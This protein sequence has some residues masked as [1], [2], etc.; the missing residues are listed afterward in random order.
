VASTRIGVLQRAVR[1]LPCTYLLVLGWR[2]EACRAECVDELNW[3]TAGVRSWLIFEYLIAGGW[4]RAWPGAVEFEFELVH[5]RVQGFRL[6]VWSQAG[7]EGSGCLRC[8]QKATLEVKFL[9]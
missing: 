1:C 9:S 5:C 4:C 6:C 7:K 8:D 3:G 2:F